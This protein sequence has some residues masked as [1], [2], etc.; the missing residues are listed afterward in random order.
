M[1]IVILCLGA[2]VRS[3]LGFGE[4]LVAVPLLALLMPVERAAPVVVLM[5]VSIATLIL[6]QDWRKV[7]LQSAAHLIVSTFLGI[8]VGLWLLHRLPANGVKGGLALIVVA[9]SIHGLRKRHVRTLGDDRLAWFFGF[10]AGVLG[11][12]YGM[13]GPP[14]ALYGALRGWRPEEFRATLQAYFLLA[15]LAGLVGFWMTGLW[16]QTVSDIYLS[17]VPGIVLAVLGGRAIHRRIRPEKFGV[18]VYG[19]LAVTGTVLLGQAVFS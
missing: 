16:T 8:P 5:S 12:A 14:L 9:V 17:A 11:G 3:T 19:G 2:L 4:A 10:N 18:Y 13:N 7:H 15:G 6:I 1:I